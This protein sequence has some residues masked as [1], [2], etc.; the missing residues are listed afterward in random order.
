MKH[1]NPG[2][3]ALAFAA[4]MALA[5][6]APAAGVSILGK[7]Q[8]VE[9]VPAPWSQPGE[10]GTLAAVGKRLLKT[11]VAFAASSVSSKFKPL[12]CKSKVI[13]TTNSIEVDALFHGN[14][15]EPNPAAAAARLGFP[16]GD[17]PS[18]DVRC[19]KSQ[20]TFHFRDADTM[21]INYDR[22]IYILKRQ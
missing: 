16:K 13:Y 5:P 20:H 19:L 21:L 14:L 18:V 9:A 8:I 1:R 4:L 7:W 2:A 6:P 11:D 22:V 15:P 17:I 3:S 10:Q 12:D